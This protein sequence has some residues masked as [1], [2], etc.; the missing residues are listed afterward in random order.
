M[1]SFKVISRL[2]NFQPCYYDIYSVNYIL[3][4]PEMQIVKSC[5]G[6]RFALKVI[7]GLLCGQPSEVWQ[8]MKRGLMK[9]QSIL[10][11]S[12]DLLSCLQNC[13]DILE[14]QEKDCFMDL[15][16]FPEGKRIRVPALIDMWAELYELD[17]DG[18]RAMSIIHNLTNKNLVNVIDT[19]CIQY[20]CPIC[21]GHLMLDHIRPKA[22]IFHMIS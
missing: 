15:G 14:D 19:R 4:S 13:L 2:E 1:Y 9:S 16:L 10:K 12:N 8:D 20:F 11:Y 3:A 5:K 22:L 21:F 6:S 17:E 18:Q 7:G